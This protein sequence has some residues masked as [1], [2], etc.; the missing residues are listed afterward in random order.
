MKITFK[1]DL[2]T[3]IAAYCKN[4]SKLTNYIESGNVKA[5]GNGNSASGDTLVLLYLLTP[6]ILQ[7]PYEAMYRTAFMSNKPLFYPHI[8]E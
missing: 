4:K 5:R 2:V 1:V 6:K 3:E 8:A 7:S